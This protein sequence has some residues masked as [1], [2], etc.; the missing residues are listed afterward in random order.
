MAI[1][2]FSWKGALIFYN[3][4]SQHLQQF[5]FV[6]FHLESLAFTLL[7]CLFRSQALLAHANFLPFFPAHAYAVSWHFSFGS[8]TT[9]GLRI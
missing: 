4:P 9:Y 5:L 1:I 8:D 7:L 3:S 6:T 2:L